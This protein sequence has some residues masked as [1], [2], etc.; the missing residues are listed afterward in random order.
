MDS[1]LL[2]HFFSEKLQFVIHIPKAQ[3]QRSYSCS[4]S[5]NESAPKPQR[6]VPCIYTSFKRSLVAGHQQT[7]WTLTFADECHSQTVILPWSIPVSGCCNCLK[8][9]KPGTGCKH[10]ALRDTPK[11]RDTTDGTPVFWLLCFLMPCLRKH[12]D[13]RNWPKLCL[14]SRRLLFF[15]SPVPQ[16]F[17]KW[18]DSL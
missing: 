18:P 9:Q 2:I 1:L 11:E 17:Q 14:D 13:K 16:L 10:S 5:H 3:K 4:L 12:L 15:A 6:R 7:A 8:T